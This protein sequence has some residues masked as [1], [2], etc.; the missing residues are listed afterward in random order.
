MKHKLLYLILVIVLS[1][2]ILPGCS[3]GNNQLST[4]FIEMME[5]VP[6]SLFQQYD[7]YYNN[8]GL[9][10]NI[11]GIESIKNFSE[12]K[13]AV[14]E[15]QDKFQ[16][17]W[18]EGSNALPANMMG[19]EK[20]IA[21]T[22]FALSSY[23][24][25][26]LIN[27]SPP[28]QTYI[29]KADLDE[30]LIKSN[31]TALGYTK[32]DYGKYGY[33]AIRDDYEPGMNDPVGAMVGL[34]GWNRLA[35]LDN[36]LIT[37]PATE[38]ITAVLDTLENKVESVMDNPVSKAVAEKLGNPLAAALTTPERIIG[39]ALIYDQAPFTFAIP[40]SW[41]TLKGYNAAA[42][43]RR[44]DAD[45]R[46]FD[47]FLYY[48]DK[49][50]AEADGQKIA[51]RMNTYTLTLLTRSSGLFTD[52][53]QP[54][55]PIVKASGKDYILSFSNLIVSEKRRTTLMLIGGNSMPVRDLLFLALAPEKYTVK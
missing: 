32:T 52:S 7:V 42:L 9:A 16:A 55:E 45:K 5:M 49:A 35:V 15:D 10:K 8:M 50:A 43:G 13:Q 47:I 11:H 36:M 28:R 51:K 6:Y 48:G 19:S 37:A 23:S 21:L 39:D 41:G 46:Y 44:A 26:V 38:F 29:I 18:N 34:S 54:G 12:Y 17:A 31:L 53:F 14:K 4:D 25:S 22:G 20:F 3:S 27:A 30:E 24:R 33:Y 1:T 40:E 2:M